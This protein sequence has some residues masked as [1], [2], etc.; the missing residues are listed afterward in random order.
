VRVPP[1]PPEGRRSVIYTAYG[2]A[3]A[4]S[5]VIFAGERISPLSPVPAAAPPR[6]ARQRRPP[7]RRAPSLPGHGRPRPAM[8]SLGPLLARSAVIARRT[9]ARRPSSLRPPP[10]A[11]WPMPGGFP[12]PERLAAPIEEL[13][14]LLP[15]QLPAR[16]ARRLPE[17]AAARA[18]RRVH[19]NTALVLL[20]DGTGALKVSGSIGLPPGES[21]LE[22][23]DGVELLLQQLH[24]DPVTVPLSI[25]TPLPGGR[26]QP[27]LA[28]PLTHGGHA[29]GLI[30]VVRHPWPGNGHVP[31]FTDGD[32]QSL[33]A[34]A[35]EL[36][37]PLRTLSLLRRLKRGLENGG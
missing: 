29:F 37:E 33:A 34:L 2:L 23:G 16:T 19:A 30:V 6:P 7:S 28:V 35:V 32:V 25:L 3:L 9:G 4:L 22:A 10:A 11:T 13:I 15:Q 12:V 24:T 18:A 20:D 5:V 21:A 27:L 14:R 26:R 17:T 31:L 8:P 36:S 1:A